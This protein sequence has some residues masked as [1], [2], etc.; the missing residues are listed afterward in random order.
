MAC[1][2]RRAA[3]LCKASKDV[4]KLLSLFL[5][6]LA[7]LSIGVVLS[8]QPSTRLRRLIHEDAQG[9]GEEDKFLEISFS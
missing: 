7:S 9:C 4:G 3:C 2:S 8:V 6:L 5:E 1:P